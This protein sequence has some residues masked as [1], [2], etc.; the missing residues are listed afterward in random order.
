MRERERGTEKGRGRG[1][2]KERERETL[3]HR[4]LSRMVPSN[5]FL[6]S[7]EDPREEEAESIIASR[8]G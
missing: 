3:E 7:L 8:D 1:K 6:Q 4:A 5:H 2:E